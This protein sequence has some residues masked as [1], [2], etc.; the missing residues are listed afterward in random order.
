MTNQS[1]QNISGLL[2]ARLLIAI[3]IIS[4]FMV[5]VSAEGGGGTKD[6]KCVGDFDIKIEQIPL[7]KPI[8]SVD[9]KIVVTDKETK[10]KVN[11]AT[12]SMDITLTNGSSLVMP[13]TETEEGTYTATLN[14][15]HSEFWGTDKLSINVEKEGKEANILAVA[16]FI[17][18]EPW[19]YAVLCLFSAYLFGYVASGIFGSIKH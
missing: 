11:G 15:E 1:N 8:D 17:G 2:I 3:I 18:I 13:L 12:V 19:Q 14:P 7:T 4:L 10:E 6:P 5:A 9:I 16:S